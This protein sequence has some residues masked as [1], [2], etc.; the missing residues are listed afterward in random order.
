MLDAL[1][2]RQDGEIPGT[3]EPTGLEH[4]PEV[5]QHRRRPVGDREH[6]V[7]EVRSGEVQ[8][9]SRKGGALVL[10]QAGV[11]A[12]N[13]FDACAAGRESTY[14]HGVT[15]CPIRLKPDA[16]SDRIGNWKSSTAAS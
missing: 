8:M 3:R 5:R 13:R 9:L 10:K 4:S 15:S 1:I 16:T 6:L 11:F 2:D 12:R 14:C 7:D